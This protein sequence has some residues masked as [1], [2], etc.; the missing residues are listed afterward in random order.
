MCIGSI[1]L[2]EIYD[3]VWCMNLAVICS[4]SLMFIDCVLLL[5]CSSFFPLL[6]Y[7]LYKVDSLCPEVKYIYIIQLH[8]FYQAATRH[9]MVF[10]EINYMLK[11]IIIFATK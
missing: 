6:I 10:R 8:Y 1:A 2:F 3:F 5:F 9:V 4:Y 7:K 11:L